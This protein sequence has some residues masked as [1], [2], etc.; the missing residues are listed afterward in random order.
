M[1]NEGDSTISRGSQ[2]NSIS[3]ENDSAL[4]P[5]QRAFAEVVGREIARFW[6]ESQQQGEA[7]RQPRSEDSSVDRTDMQRRACRGG[8]AP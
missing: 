6:R 8:F 4:T 7:L 2:A 5:Q 3:D 1:P